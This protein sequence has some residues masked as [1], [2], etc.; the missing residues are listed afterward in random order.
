VRENIRPALDVGRA[1]LIRLSVVAGLVV[2]LG[3]ALVTSIS[4]ADAQQTT[5]SDAELRSAYCFS[6]LSHNLKDY[7]ELSQ[8]PMSLGELKNSLS[9]DQHRTEL[10]QEIIGLQKALERTDFVHQ[11]DLNNFDRV[12]AHLLASDTLRKGAAFSQATARA[13]ADYAQCR[14]ELSQH[15]CISVPGKG[16][17]PLCTWDWPASDGQSEANCWNHC[18]ASTCVRLIQCDNPTWLPW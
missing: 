8:G 5:I 4:R 18:G 17:D 1:Q 9:R 2:P 15:L 12:R 13:D 16:G 6:V 14:K 11:R 10:E 3:A 7:E